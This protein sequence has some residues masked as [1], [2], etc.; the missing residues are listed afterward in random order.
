MKRF[1]KTL[2]RTVL[3]LVTS[4][5]AVMAVSTGVAGVLGRRYG[6]DETQV[7]TIVA[8]GLGFVLAQGQADKGKEAAKIVAAGPLDK[9]G[10]PAP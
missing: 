10:N 5:K 8:S 6:L 3:E 2:G 4:K 9:A 7:A 1:F